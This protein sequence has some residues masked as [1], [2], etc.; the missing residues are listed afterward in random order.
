MIGC[1]VDKTQNWDEDL[2][3]LTAAYQSSQHAATGYTQNQLMLGREVHQLNDIWTGV[4][5][6]QSN[7]KEVSE[8]LHDLE[9]RMREARDTAKEHLWVT[10]HRQKKLCDAS[11]EERTFNIGNVV[12]ASG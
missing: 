2:S 6:L 4:A 5:K 3:L 1:Y 7:P 11:A 10:Q 8:F 12:Y 9:E